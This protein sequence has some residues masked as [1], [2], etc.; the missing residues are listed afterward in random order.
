MNE[1]IFNFFLYVGPGDVISTI[2]C[3]AHQGNGSDEE[4]LAFLKARVDSDYAAA[5]RFPVPRGCVIVDEGGGKLFGA[6]RWPVFNRLREMNRHYEV[7]EEVFQALDAPACPLS[8]I[9]AIVN[10][11]PRIDGEVTFTPVSR[12]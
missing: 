11:K 5:R 12:I 7:L 10:G 4:K 6:I 9:T 1:R 2:G 8:V 3:V